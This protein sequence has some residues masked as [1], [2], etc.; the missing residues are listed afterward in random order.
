LVEQTQPGAVRLAASNLRTGARAIFGWGGGERD[1][2]ADQGRQWGL[3]FEAWRARQ[4]FLPQLT[5]GVAAPSRLAAWLTDK[6]QEVAAFKAQGPFPSVVAAQTDPALAT[7]TGV[8][9]FFNAAPISAILSK[10]A[11][12]IKAQFKGP[13]DSTIQD[14]VFG[15]SAIALDQGKSGTQASDLLV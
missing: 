11:E 3:L 14:Q 4:H 15:P 7:A 6:D 10:R 2:A 12:G 13:D 1:V 9:A 8:S 5:D